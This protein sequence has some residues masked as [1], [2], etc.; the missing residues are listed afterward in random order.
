M[1]VFTHTI[2]SNSLIIRYISATPLQ[3]GV[4]D[5]REGWMAPEWLERKLLICRDMLKVAPLCIEGATLRK[6]LIINYVSCSEKT[7]GKILGR[8]C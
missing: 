1:R 7:A 8:L 2:C 6:E 3:N 5:S 4:E